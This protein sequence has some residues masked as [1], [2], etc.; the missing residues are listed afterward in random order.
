MSSDR[1]IKEQY[2]M[3]L[4]RKPDTGGLKTYRQQ[5]PEAVSHAIFTSAERKRV[6]KREAE[7]DKLRTEQRELIAKIQNELQVVKHARETEQQKAATRADKLSAK[8]SEL[9]AKIV[10][11]EAEAQE[12]GSPGQAQPLTWQRVIDFVLNKLGR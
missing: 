11:L 4:H 12:E 2:L 9:Q 7:Q 3:G 5:A 6:L 8:V 10:R 1:F